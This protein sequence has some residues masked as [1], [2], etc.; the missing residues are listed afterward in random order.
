MAAEFLESFHGYLETDA[1]SGYKALEKEQAQ[2][3]A[4][5]CW[6]HAR[7]DFSDALKAV[8][9]K[10]GV[11]IPQEGS[12]AAQALY[13]NLGGMYR[14]NGKLEL[15]KENM[16]QAIRIMDEYGLAYYHDSVVLITNYAVLLTDMGQPDVGL[17][18]LKKLCRV[19]RE[20]NSDT[21][22]DYASVQVAMENIN[23]IM[24]KIQQATSHF[25]KAMEI[26]EMAF[27]V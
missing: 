7:R 26:Y 20:Y 12:V 19:I 4:A 24:G 11:P 25:Q 14:V 22:L 17:S 16:E 3:T 23:L 1:F 2:I 15:A 21:G 8:G 5:F 6:A 27:E 13:A 9:A 18:A 10:N